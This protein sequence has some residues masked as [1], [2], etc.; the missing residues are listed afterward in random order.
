MA[1]IILHA[2]NTG[3]AAEF[4]TALANVFEHSPWIA[5]AAAAGRPYPTLAELRKAMLGVIDMASAEQR[6]ALICA[7]PDLANK[8]QRAEGLT[9]DSTSE[10]DGAGLD[11]LSE[12]EF[13][14]FGR[15]N[16]AY[17][18]KFGIPFIVCVKR[19]SKDSI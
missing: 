16:D 13:A 14:L 10:Q 2:L 9:V 15:L 4:R 5:E 18:A 3:S 17:K 6:L 1:K 7:H 19:H 8:A 12:A 11:R